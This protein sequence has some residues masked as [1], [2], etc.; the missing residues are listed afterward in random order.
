MCCARRVDQPADSL[1]EDIDALRALALNAIAERDAAVAERDLN[2]RLRRL[3]RKAQGL[4][5][6]SERLARLDPDQLNLAPKDLEQAV[7]KSEALEEKTRAAETRKTANQSRRVASPFA[8]HSRERCGRSGLPLLQE[9]NALDRRR[10]FRAAR[11]DPG[12]IPGDCHASAEVRLP[13]LR[14][15]RG[16]A[17]AGASDQIR[18]ADGSDGRLGAGG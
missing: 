17:G 12:S 11:R 16:A 15:D 8:A 5:A 1:P 9:A 14:T 10:D 7:A 6:K 2:E 13:L 18:T 4:E 3:L